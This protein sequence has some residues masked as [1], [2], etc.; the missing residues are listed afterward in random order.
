VQHHERRA[1]AV[2]V[3]A[4]VEPV[5]LD[6]RQGASSVIEAGIRGARPPRATAYPP[7]TMTGIASLTSSPWTGPD[8]LRAMEALVSASWL[9]PARPLV[10]CTIGDLEWW[11]ALGGPSV[12][13]SA[14]IRIWSIG[15]DPVAWAW[16]TPPASLDWF[17]SHELTPDEEHAVRRDILAWLADVGRE[18]VAGGAS[19]LPAAANPPDSMSMTVWAADGWPESALLGHFGWSAT[20][21]SLTQYHQPLDVDLDPPRVPDGYV[22]RSVR[23][24]DD[25]PERV[26]VHRAAFAPSKMTDEKYR[27]A[28]AQ[29]HYAAERDIVLE[30]P[31]G[32]FAAFAMCWADPV[33]SIGEFEPVGVHPD[34]QRR[35]LGRVIMRHG[36]RLMR[37][38]GLRDALVFSFR[39]NAASEALYRSAGFAEVAVH[40]QYTK[41]IASG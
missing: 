9:S 34:H 15:G 33:G 16:L 36:L 23:L 13:W 11:L 5:G 31:D 12:D 2:D 37:A 18:A 35:G 1:R 17:V 29:D 20:D 32:T 27:I 24:P 21:V 7:E 22:L 8:D 19:A 6:G 4:D 41:P 40:R 10:H 25:I 14:R 3:I 30:A 38:A 39:S 26:A 28:I